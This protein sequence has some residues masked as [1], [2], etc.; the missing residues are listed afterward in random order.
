LPAARTPGE[1]TKHLAFMDGMRGLAILMVVLYHLDEALHV[2]LG[3]HIGSVW[4]GIKHFVDA[5]FL[6]VEVF[7]FISGFVLFYPYAQHLFED[8]PLQ[9]L[10]HFANRRALKIIPSYVFS[11][12]FMTVLIAITVP[13]APHLL[14]DYFLHLFFI[15]NTVP[16]AFASINGPLWS[17]AI[18]VQFYLLFPLVCWSFR[19]WPLATP[20][21][22][23]AVAGAYRYYLEATGNSWSFF[24]VY[25]LPGFLDFFALGMGVAYLIV[26]LRS[27]RP[28]VLRFG[29][30]FAAVSFAAVL[31]IDAM[32]KN[33]VDTGG[34]PVAWHWE[35][36]YHPIF[37][38]LIALFAFAGALAVPVW[39]NLVANRV[40]VFLA[41]ISYNLYLWNKFIIVW[42]K[43]H[44]LLLLYALS[45]HAA[46]YFVYGIAVLCCV[47]V[48]VATTYLLER[49]ILQNGWKELWPWRAGAAKKA[50]PSSP[51]S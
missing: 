23:I 1:F 5:G 15:H 7:F 43:N 39:Q 10:A 30:A 44:M 42:L 9:T 12:T 11:L 20:M 29:W 37:A 35:N 17:L 14:R 40:L 25:Q 24:Y 6:G 4:F 27:E 28:R 8:K 41:V 16:D 51:L 46:P 38:V 48:A 49:P 36:T 32:F 47:L 18:E 19:R 21:L 13:A 45:P 3:V 34:G 22:M 50:S 26:M 2:P 33:L 31:G